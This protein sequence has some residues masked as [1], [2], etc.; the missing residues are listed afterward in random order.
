MRQPGLIIPLLAIGLAAG[1]GPMP[2]IAATSGTGKSAETEVQFQWAMTI[3]LRDGVELSGTL[4]RPRGQ[5]DALPCVFTLTPYIAASYHERGMYFAANGYVFASIDTR[6]RGN[7][8]G[9]FTPLLQEA[10]DGHDVVQWLAKQ[11]YCNGKVTMWGGSYAGYNQWATAKEFPSA[12]TSIVPVASPKPG[13]DFPMRSNMLYSYAMTWLT[14][15]S[16]K[17]AQDAI[18]GDS[19]FWNAQF[20]HWYRDGAPFARLDEYVG[21]PSPIFQKWI[22]HP[23]LD[24]YWDSFSP[25]PEQLARL[26]L[27]ILS[28]TGYYDGDQPGALA[29]YDDHMRHGNDAAKA[30]HY[31]ILGPWDH[32]GTRTPRAEVGGL[33]FGKASLLDMNA[34]HKA[35]YDWTLKDGPKPEF[36]KDKVAFYIVGEDAWR[37]APDLAAVTASTRTVYLDSV[38]SRANSVFASGSL[39]DDRPGRSP[40]DQYL[41]DPLAEMAAW[42]EKLESQP[43]PLVDQRH[44]LAPEAVGLV[45]HT[46]PFEKDTDIAGRFRLTAYIE[47]DQPDTD[48]QVVVEEITIDGSSVL[49]TYDTMRARYRNSLREATLVKPGTIEPY[50]FERFDFTARRIARGS[51]LRLTIAPIGSRHGERNYHTGGVVAQ[52]SAEQSRP[53]RVRLHHDRRHPSALEIP[54]AAKSSVAAD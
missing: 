49:L 54:L 19:A 3:P 17:A 45:Y 50:V 23:T 35:W 2:A 47:L 44:A 31:L 9:E 26:Q 43:G 51:R 5:V 32:P 48:F 33:T 28:I 27:P 16:G 22:S 38:Q 6:G 42:L 39:S 15:V 18:F 14:L 29:L 24:A 34:L 13:V 20:E 12:L 7:S 8:G 41:F 37:Y 25:T 21:N 10:Q 40:P 52:E 36:L 53:V 1:A 4:Y 11:P 30:Q 46:A